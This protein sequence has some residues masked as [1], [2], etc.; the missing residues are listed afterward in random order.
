VGQ[1]QLQNLEKLEK[2]GFSQNKLY[3]VNRFF[4]SCEFLGVSVFSETHEFNTSL[5]FALQARAQK[6]R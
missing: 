1:K 5:C 2:S 3:H 6:Q 4:S